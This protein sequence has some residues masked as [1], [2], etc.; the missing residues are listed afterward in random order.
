MKHCTI[1]LQFP[2]RHCLNFEPAETS[3]T[4]FES[5]LSCQEKHRSCAI[6]LSSTRTSNSEV[7]CGLA[8]P[9]FFWYQMPIIEQYTAIY[10]VSR[11]LLPKTTDICIAS[12][13]M[14]STSTVSSNAVLFN[15]ITCS[16]QADQPKTLPLQNF[17]MP[18]FGHN[19]HHF[20][21]Q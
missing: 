16:F 1:D 11:W 5:I 19:V 12:S 17:Y 21:G 3:E 14:S 6:P 13:N 9:F 10:T 20:F 4:C 15:S 2:Q 8:R 7:A 18:K